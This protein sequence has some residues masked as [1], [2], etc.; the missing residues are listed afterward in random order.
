MHE[1]LN[2]MGKDY[3][4]APTVDLETFMGGGGVQRTGAGTNP[5]S[6]LCC[7]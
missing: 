3:H 1:L 7:F 5:H 2:P 6:T 4:Q